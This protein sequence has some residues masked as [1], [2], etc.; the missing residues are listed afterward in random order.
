MTYRGVKVNKDGAGNIFAAA[1]LGEKSLV[2]TA[3][4]NFIGD[5]G[6][7]ATIG[8]EAMLKQVPIAVFGG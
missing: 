5:I 2:G 7:V 3:T 8:L 1:G 4:A 6:I